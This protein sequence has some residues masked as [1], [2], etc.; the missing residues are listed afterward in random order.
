MHFSLAPTLIICN[1][2]LWIVSEATLTGDQMAVQWTHKWLHDLEIST[3]EIL[4][5]HDITTNVKTNK[6]EELKLHL[7]KYY[8]SFDLFW[9]EFWIFLRFGKTY[10]DPRYVVRIKIFV[11]Y[12]SY[13]VSLKCAIVVGSICAGGREKRQNTENNDLLPV[14]SVSRFSQFLQFTLFNMFLR[15]E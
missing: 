13:V 2:F 7:M 12:K 11:Q 3:L 6:Q 14:F 10:V 1:F 9:T 8:L 15:F 4:L 5:R